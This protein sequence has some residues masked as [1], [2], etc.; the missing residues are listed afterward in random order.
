MGLCPGHRGIKPRV[1]QPAKCKHRALLGLSGGISATSSH[2]PFGNRMES[3][4]WMVKKHHCVYSRLNTTKYDFRARLLI[5]TQCERKQEGVQEAGGR[6][7]GGLGRAL[8]VCRMGGFPSPH[9]KHAS[10]MTGCH[11]RSQFEPTMRGQ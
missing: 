5:Y 6:H 4:G 3:K 2:V 7:F 9:H 8:E 11:Q 10:R 1:R